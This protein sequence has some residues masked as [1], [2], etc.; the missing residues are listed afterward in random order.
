MAETKSGKRRRA[1]KPLAVALGVLVLVLGL[2]LVLQA[3]HLLAVGRTVGIEDPD[4]PVILCLG[5]S[6]T[7]GAGVSADEAYP[8]VLERLIREAGGRAE[9]ANLGAPGVNTSQVRRM[10]PGLLD[11]HEPMAVVVLAGVNNGWNRRYQTWSDAEDGLEAPLGARARDFLESEVRT[12]RLLR[13]LLHR[14]NWAG[15]PEEAAKDR[16]GRAILHRREEAWKVETAREGYERARRDLMAI[17]AMTRAAH[18]VPVLMTYVSDP[19]YTFET[20]NRLLRQVADEM[21]AAIADNDRAIA[22]TFMEDGEWIAEKRR[23][24]FLPDMH[25]AA[26]GHELIAGN[27]F[28]TLVEQGVLEMDAWNGSQP[29]T[30]DR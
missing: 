11:R 19:E 17:V 4:A 16:G 28:E 13:V 1:G 23:R 24:L 10:L 5:D 27:V 21:N 14:L 6:H 9:V 7:Y 25:P 26:Q 30:P 8:A 22:P 20:P 3:G 15:S 18:A 12:V 2:E 29:H